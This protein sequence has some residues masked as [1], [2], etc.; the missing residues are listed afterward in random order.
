M[1][2]HVSLGGGRWADVGGGCS[3]GSSVFDEGAGVVC[4]EDAEYRNFGG[5]R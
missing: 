4:L 2:D 5:G 1:L 3:N